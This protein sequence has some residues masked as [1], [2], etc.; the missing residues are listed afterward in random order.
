MGARLRADA[1][2]N[3]T[4][5]G[6]VFTSD[7]AGPNPDDPQLRNDHGVNFRVSD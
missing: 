4:L 5:I 6:G 2:D 3:L 1:R 7:S